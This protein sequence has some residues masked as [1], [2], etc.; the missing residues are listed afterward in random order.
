VFLF[1]GITETHNDVIKYRNY[2]ET[3]EILINNTISIQSNYTG[4]YYHFTI[5]YG[6]MVGQS[7]Y[8]TTDY[9]YAICDY[10]D[11]QCL[12][13]FYSAHCKRTVYFQ[14]NNPKQFVY[15]EIVHISDLSIAYYVLACLCLIG[16]FIIWRLY[17]CIGRVARIKLLDNTDYQVL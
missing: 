16:I 7:A 5:R 6:F 13:D 12:I 15:D 4:D 14:Q 10:N 8:N 17:I 1:Y 2:V 9:M 11:L 3:K